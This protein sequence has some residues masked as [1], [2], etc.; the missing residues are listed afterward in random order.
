[1]LAGSRPGSV[2]EVAERLGT[3]QVDPTRTTERAERLTVWS[4]LGSYDVDEIRRLLEDERS[5]F[6]YRA[7]LIPAADLPLHLPVMRRY[8]RP[9]Y[10]RGRYERQ[11]LDDNAGFRAYILSELR[12]RGPLKS[13][14]LDDRAVV[15]WQTGGWNDGKN[16]SRMLEILANAGEISI[17]RREGSERVWDL[18]ERVLPIDAEE[19]P[20]EVVA[21]QSLEHQLRARGLARSNFG[22]ALDY[23]L[24][25]RDAALDGLLADGVAVPVAVEGSDWAWFAHAELLGELDASSWEPR[26]TLL[27]PFDPL[28]ADRDRTVQLFAFHFRTEIYVPAAKR[29]F[30]FYVLPILHDDR[31]IGRI[32]PVMDRKQ[33]VLTLNAVHAE[34]DAPADAWP[35]IR[36]AIDEL[37]TWLGAERVE[38]PRLPPAWR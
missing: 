19:L 11:W 16:L 32:D 14:D 21:F 27:G 24:P 4:R 17:S 3:L 13:R 26:T 2:L 29:E 15:P 12:D 20:D 18:S 1:M 31:L 7:H 34:T 9:K 35:A 10:K 37:A 25:M 8:P 33:V 36:S 38:L 30:G 28:I 23:E 5:L 6:E 22:T